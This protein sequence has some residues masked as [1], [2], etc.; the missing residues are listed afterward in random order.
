MEEQWKDIKG[1]EGYYQVS[2]HG[3]VRSLDRKNSR[4]WSIPGKVM[5]T[6]LDSK[7]YPMYPFTGTDGRTTVFTGWCAGPL[8]GSRRAN[9]STFAT[10]TE[11][12]Q[13]MSRQI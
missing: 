8:T 1:Y 2:D 3:R 6:P 12:G 4:G 10:M 11:R 7:G 9:R 5:A 13:T